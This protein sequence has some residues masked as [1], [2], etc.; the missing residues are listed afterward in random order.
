MLMSRKSRMVDIL[1]KHIWY[2]INE[3]KWDFFY[4]LVKWYFLNFSSIKKEGVHSELVTRIQM[5]CASEWVYFSFCE[6]RTGL[7]DDCP[8]LVSKL[9]YPLYSW[10]AYFCHDW[11]CE[12]NSWLWVPLSGH[13]A[14]LCLVS[15]V[16]W[17]LWWAFTL[18][19]V[20]IRLLTS[21]CRL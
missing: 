20:L 3:S 10:P 21:T 15:D 4:Y 1:L 13:N 16:W 9:C 14:F 6:M 17:T 12:Q 2:N 18:R 19:D 7:K 11:L 8:P 5:W